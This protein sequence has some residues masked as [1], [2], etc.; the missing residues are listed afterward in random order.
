MT[1]PFSRVHVLGV[2]ETWSLK[3][4]AHFLIQTLKSLGVDY[5]DRLI[6]A[7]QIVY[8]ANKYTAPSSQYHRLGNKVLFDYFHGHPSI[9]KEFAPLFE[10]I[11]RRKG[12][13]SGIRVSNSQIEDLFLNNGFEGKVFRIPLEVP[14]DWFTLGTPESKKMIRRELGI[15][16][17]SIVLGSFQ[18][19]G[20]GWGDGLTPKLIK[21][22]DVLLKTLSILQQRT[23]NIFVLLTG[24]ARG[25]VKSGLARLGIP[26]KHEFIEYPDLGKFYHALDVYLVS[27]REEGGPKAILESMA[28]G[29]P[30]VTTKVGQAR[31]LVKHE[32]NGWVAPVGDC[33][34]LALWVEEVIS[35]SSV[36]S[37]VAR[38]GRLTA[39]K[40]SHQALA[41]E[42]A[43][44][45]KPFMNSRI[46]MRVN[47]TP[48]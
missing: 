5:S 11:C 35:D 36:A 9:S 27:S 25:Y 18:K 10:R 41:P 37:R 33:E 28:S 40:Y 47:S 34:G 14:L 3:W 17:S 43:T 13:F 31:D 45:L 7:R 39:E 4:D 1:F 8:L 42:W 19:D 6:T 23:K 46:E 29:V 24:P 30:L 26:Y 48:F 21:G 32:E 15:P 20:V 16:E 44:F 22:P 38:Q 2:R 12:A